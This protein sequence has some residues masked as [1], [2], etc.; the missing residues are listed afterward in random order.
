[1]SETY[2]RQWSMLRSIPR[3]PRKITSSELLNLLEDEGY[4]IS[5]RTIERDLNSLSLV[6]PIK[7]DD[8]NKPFGW[9]WMGN[10]VMD[11]PSMDIPVALSFALVSQFLQP[12]LP[13]SSRDHLEPHFRQA[14]NV[15]KNTEKSGQG[16]WLDKIRIL[17]RGQKL[18]PAN[19]SSSILDTVYE[20]LLTDKRINIKYQASEDSEIKEYEVNPLG[21][22][23]RDASVYMVSSLW[24]YDD[25][26]QLVLH[27]IKKAT[28]SD[29][30]KHTPKG[31]TLDQ[32]ISS[33]EFGYKINEQPINLKVLFGRETVSHLRE[34]K[35]SEDQTLKEQSDGRILLTANVLD[36][37]ELR[38]W[39]MGFGDCVEVVSPKRLR[40]EFKVMAE[41]LVNKYSC[42][43]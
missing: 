33:G 35:L 23:F 20:A 9:Q 36:T 4:Q 18:I 7:C 27:R 40:T 11:I 32:Y 38:W 3:K 41:N 5:K 8:R 2:L 26:K 28:V 13:R 31:F 19:I 6:F 10:E 29:K 25:I 37:Q 30:F 1:M 12:L 17:H 22:V 14:T 39:L 43:T 15:L 21:L 24:E 34:T 42:A 16:K